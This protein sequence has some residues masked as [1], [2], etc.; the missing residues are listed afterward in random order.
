[1]A[2]PRDRLRLAGALEERGFVFKT[3]YPI[4]LTLG[5][6]LTPAALS[7]AAGGD[8]TPPP[9]TL[10]Q[11]MAD[12]D[13]IGGVPEDPYWA[14]DGAAI[15]YRRKQQGHELRDLYRLD[16]ATAEAR[17]VPLAEEGKADQPSPA[18]SHNRQR[19][20]YVRDG[21]LFVKELPRGP[22][23]QLARIA[24][25]VTDPQF[26]V[27]DREV[28]FRVGEDFYSYDL[29]TGLVAQLTDLQLQK[30]PAEED[31]DPSF[32][33]TQQRQLFEALRQHRAEVKDERERER[34]RR[35]SDPTRAPLTWYLGE[36]IRIASR[37]LSPSG[38]WLLL[39]TEPK[40]AKKPKQERMPNYVTESGYIEDKEVRSL[41]GTTSPVP[42]KIV[43]L[44]LKTRERIEL[45]TDQLPG[46]LTDP[47]Q[48]LR[49]KAAAAKR[50][51]K[52]EAGRSGDEAAPDVEAK[53]DDRAE[54]DQPTA[55]S[56]EKTEKAKESKKPKARPI[57]V[58]DISWSEDGRRAALELQSADHKDR[59]LATLDPADRRLVCRHHLVDPAWINWD[60]NDF[61]WLRD[62]DTLYLLSEESGYSHLYLLS[63]RDGTSRPLTHGEFEVTKP[64]LS[65]D[66]RFLYYLANV[67]HP[68]IH[69]VWRVDLKSG[70]SEQITRLGGENE[71]VLSPDGGRLLLLHSEI[72]R[73]PELYLQ[74]SRPGATARRL[75]QTISAEFLAQRWAVPEIV[76][77]PSTHVQ[78]PLYARV[79][80]PAAA[81]TAATSP[82][83]KR[84]AV[85]FIHG[86]GYLQEADYGWSYYFH[87]FMF[88][89]LLVE[90]G[91]VVLDMDYRAS[92][93]YGRAWRTAIYRG[94]GHPELEDL[95]D[96]VAWLVSHRD[97]DPERIGV[98]GGSYGGFL[99]LMALFRRPQLFAAGAA[100][101]PV[102][103]WAHY[104]DDYT[105]AILNT[106]E[107]DP[108][109]YRTSSPIEDAD[110][111]A[112]PLLICAGMEDDN[113]FF[114]DDV[115]LVERLIELK[116]ENFSLAP[117]PLESHAFKAPVAWLDEYRR[118]LKL[119]E[120]TLK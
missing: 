104:N 75:V 32:L 17:I 79:F 100:L 66:G 4:A 58:M 5:A 51:A 38:E 9:V 52:A 88:H 91:Y 44:D 68:G 53:G 28:A 19:K 65:R 96:G 71:F 14:E 80:S 31:P 85:V 3:A 77:I 36:K 21:D 72:A 67:T 7:G 119:F 16:L 15:Y 102:T 62:G 34:A 106:P 41:V 42:Q 25:A 64:A 27:G 84:P 94:M 29:A 30:D 105:A 1:M 33:V 115:R 55:E 107:V 117:Y 37:S 47:L 22:F 26:M 61:G 101:R 23:R 120:T 48:E 78:A 118:I 98:Y 82:G 70:V 6:L 13:W 83:K 81:A 57:T 63:A 87:E 56:T 49:D 113:V 43:L 74:E 11:I 110:G 35:R 40:D 54:E 89:T 50:A 20:A 93:G 59:W 12:P 18:L 39:V 24:R 76:A 103:D 111:L 73:P 45:A 109:A 112:H 114:K 108:E 92:Q 90:R 97:V 10:E 69:E 2:P 99:T 86:A 116:K 46:I 60:Y 8:T 95:E